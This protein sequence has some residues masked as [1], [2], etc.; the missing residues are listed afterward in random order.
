MSTDQIILGSVTALLLVLILVLAALILYTIFRPGNGKGIDPCP[1]CG[2]PKKITQ[3]V[4]PECAREIPEDAPYLVDQQGTSTEKISVPAGGLTIG[5]HPENRLHLEETLVSRQHARIVIE[6]GNYVLYDLDSANGTWVNDRQIG[7]RILQAGDVIQIGL[8]RFVYYRS[9]E[10]PRISIS[11]VPLEEPRPGHRINGYQL[12]DIIGRGGMSVVFR[13][14]TSDGREVALKILQ[15]TQDYLVDKFI[16]EGK[17]IGPLLRR[18]PHIVRVEDFGESQSGHRYIVMEYV[19]GLSLRKELGRPLDDPH[20]IQRIVG[21]T[22]DALRYAH[23]CGVIHRDIKPENILLTRDGN[24]KVTDFGIAKLT[25]AVTV[26]RDKIVGT[27]EYMSYEQAQGERV[28]TT[29]DLYSLG[30]V[31]YEMLT[32][33]VPF[34]RPRDLDD[35][36]ASMKVIEMHIKQAPTPPSKLN[37][38]ISPQTEQVTLRALEKSWKKRFRAAPEMGRAMGWTQYSDIQPPV[39]F[40]IVVR[41]EVVGGPQRGKVVPIRIQRPEGALIHRE[42]L[43]PKDT[44][45][46]RQHAVL[47]YRAGQF[48]IEDTSTN[49]T[50]LNDRRVYGEAPLKSGDMLRM[51]RSELRFTQ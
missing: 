18:H 10:S 23:E 26:T 38:A 12:K 2:K 39:T 17:N 19:D 29:S 9:S 24:V 46:S 5:R 3:I 11:P 33:T 25:S 14:V 30:I 42:D 45:L 41:F 13:A 16:Q 40:P 6:D 15:E 1:T 27:P 47:T 43:N 22:C 44:W 48:W 36:T 49:G 50:F 35:R 51:G 4:C 7:R 28:N 20:L 8:T 34:R 21:Q 37:P 32:G 31:L